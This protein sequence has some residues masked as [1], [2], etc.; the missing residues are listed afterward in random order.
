MKK[1]K[2]SKYRYAVLLSGVMLIG[3][4]A[5]TN[6]GIGTFCNVCPVGFLQISLASRQIP[7]DMIV[8]VA[9]A[10]AAIVV[11]GRFFCG[12]LCPTTFIRKTCQKQD[13]KMT[14]MHKQGVVRLLPYAVLVLALGISFVMRFPVFCLACPIGLFFG[15]L[16]ALFKLIFAVEP[17]WNL[18]IFPIMIGLEVL[19]F[20]KWCSVICPIGAIFSLLH[21][22]RFFR[23]KP[24]V[25]HQTCLQH[26]GSSCT[27]CVNV[28]E[29]GVNIHASQA[30][31]VQRCTNCLTCLDACPTQSISLQRWT[32]SQQPIKSSAVM[33]A[34]SKDDL[35][36]S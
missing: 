30:S 6:V 28:C 22:V 10:V 34:S 32:L 2:I 1:I 35:H 18:V 4:G 7:L 17:S 24:E 19:L 33:Q 20:K 9:L 26:S 21:K 31:D 15:F 29:E 14:K 27:V 16:F 5:V 8:G 13:S 25:N 3:V 12:W 36:F 23:I 11:L